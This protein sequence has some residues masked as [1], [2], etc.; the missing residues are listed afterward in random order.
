M[1]NEKIPRIIRNAIIFLL[2]LLTISAFITGIYF[3]MRLRFPADTVI[4]G[5][6]VSDMLYSDAEALLERSINEYSIK[7]TVGDQRLEIT[8]DDIGIVFKKEDFEN[9]VTSVRDTGLA[10]DP[11]SIISLD[12][13]KLTACIRERFDEKRMAFVPSTIMWD[14]NKSQFYATPCEPE[15]WYSHE[16]LTEIVKDSIANLTA[17]LVVSEN[18]LYQEYTD[19]AQVASAEALAEKANELMT[20]EL[21]YVFNPRCV[22]LGREVLENTTIASF[23]RF[24]P[25]NNLVYADRDAVSAY[26]EGIASNYDYIKYKDRFVTHDGDRIEFKI[27]IQNQTV[28]KDKLTSL[29]EE[30]IASGTSGSFE[31]P[32]IGAL[33]F[34]GTYI[35]VSIP[36]QHLWYYEDGVVVLES[37]VV[38]GWE[39]IGRRT[40]TGLNYIR[41]HLSN[42]EL[43]N[44]YPVDYWMSFT[45]GGIYGFHDA[46]N[47]RE[48][49]EYG[50]KTYETDGSGGCVNVPVA[51][52]EKLYNMVADGTPIMIYNYYNYD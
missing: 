42:I 17:E 13:K 11:W 18:S 26:V 23:L 6:K 9:V 34:D 46:D 45:P 39:G 21:E 16:I 7:V 50:G 33:N 4:C 31:V 48:P 2:I 10:A 38:T 41:G 28:D 22:E 1:T 8:A 3:A 43:F 14:E 51:N 27:N 20:L 36:Q 35:E 25:D 37:D 47:W 49:E 24:D 52:M 12:Q 40:P 44:D 32:Y 29:I 15:T 19:T 30:C 5:V